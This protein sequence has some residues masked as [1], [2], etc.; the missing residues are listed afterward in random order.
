[1]KEEGNKL[2]I[3]IILAMVLPGSG[4]IYLADKYRDYGIKI[5]ILFV[6]VTYLS[7]SVIFPFVL[8]F[9]S[10]LIESLGLPY[11]LNNL[12]F[13]IISPLQFL[14]SFIIWYKQLRNILRITKAN[15]I[16]KDN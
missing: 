14:P 6:I 15:V 12:L 13:P 5:S 10:I 1:M 3:A 16:T 11:Q 4:H 8:G 2:T 7:N 9:L